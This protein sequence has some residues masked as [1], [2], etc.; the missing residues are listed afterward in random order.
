M[1]ASLVS[2]LGETNEAL[3][4][5]LATASG[6]THAQLAAAGT[7]T[8]RGEQAIVKGGGRVAPLYIENPRNGAALAVA[9]C[10]CRMPRPA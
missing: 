3:Q 6:S 10:A 8:G 1:L 7:V 4:R 5:R 9:P 2:K